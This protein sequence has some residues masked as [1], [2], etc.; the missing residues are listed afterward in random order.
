[1]TCDFSK[2]PYIFSYYSSAGSSYKD[3][4]EAKGNRA[5]VHRNHTVRPLAYPQSGAKASL[6]EVTA[7]GALIESRPSVLPDFS[8]SSQMVWSA[9]FTFNGQIR[10]PASPAVEHAKKTNKQGQ[11]RFR[12]GSQWQVWLIR[13]PAESWHHQV[14]RNRQS[15]VVSRARDYHRV[16]GVG[17]RSEANK[18]IERTKFI[19]PGP[20]LPYASPGCQGC[21]KLSLPDFLLENQVHLS[22]GCSFSHA[23]KH[24][25]L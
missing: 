4:C 12:P 23:L 8:F 14:D 25:R 20:C 6:L 10:K 16:L 24:S 21:L 5:T 7:P 17:G 1:M 13:W 11:S 3:K 19:L 9:T 18:E 15:L 22:N 2:T